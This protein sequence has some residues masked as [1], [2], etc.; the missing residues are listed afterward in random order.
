MPAA[1]LGG[2]HHQSC[3][4]TRLI[5][6]DVDMKRFQFGI[7]QILLAIALIAITCG[8]F[9][10]YRNI[11]GPPALRWPKVVW[12]FGVSA[13]FWALGLFIGY[14]IGRRTFTAQLVVIFALTQLVALFVLWAFV[15]PLY[16]L[17][18]Y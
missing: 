2:D 14:A 16:W 4:F 11:W 12:D 17:S 3:R 13:P 5:G 15:H 1:A 8:A 9:A 6:Y 10:A 7:R 18:D